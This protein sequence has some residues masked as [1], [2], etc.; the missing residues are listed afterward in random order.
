LHLPV[1]FT[2]GNISVEVT[3]DSVH[4][5]LL[6][7]GIVNITYEKGVTAVSHFLGSKHWAPIEQLMGQALDE[8]SDLY[9]VG[10]VA[11]NAFTGSEPYAGSATEAAVAVAMGITPIT[12]P[13]L[14]D[15]PQDVIDM[16]NACLSYQRDERPSN[17][18]DCLDVLERHL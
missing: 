8:R 15:V 13:P 11:Y 3:G 6:D 18:R 7:L 14:C 4:S 5:T 16:I 17:A 2:P 1:E 10:A 12:L 9:S